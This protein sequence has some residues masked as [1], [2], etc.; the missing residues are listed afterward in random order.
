[1]TWMN[2]TDNDKLLSVDPHPELQ[3]V[4]WRQG[5]QGLGWIFWY[6][7]LSSTILPTHP[8]TSAL[9]LPSLLVTDYTPNFNPSRAIHHTAHLSV[10]PVNQNLSS[11]PCCIFG[12][13]KRILHICIIWLSTQCNVVKFVI[14]MISKDGTDDCQCNIERLG[15]TVSFPEPF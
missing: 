8:T 5:G 3:E 7:H 14:F 15:C 6:F 9:F 13:R 2:E 10:T 11:C 1:M 4:K 12:S